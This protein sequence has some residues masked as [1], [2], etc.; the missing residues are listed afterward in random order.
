M[1]QETYRPED[2][3]PEKFRAETAPSSDT[4]ET[5]EQR[6]S[7]PGD[8]SV[9]MMQFGRN[10]ASSAGKNVMN[11]GQ[12][13]TD[14]AGGF[15]QTVLGQPPEVLKHPYE[16]FIKPL[17]QHYK[18][19]YGSD[20]SFRP[21]LGKIGH[22]LYEDPV[23]V[24]LDV[25]GV[26]QP[27]SSAL[28]TGARLASASRLANA[29]KT[30]DAA[31]TPFS[32]RTVGTV[33]AP[34]REKVATSLYK[35][36]LG[37]LPENMERKRGAIAKQGLENDI[38]LGPT[39]S[40]ARKASSAVK[41][42][43]EKVNGII[44]EIEAKGGK[45]NP[46]NVAKSIERVRQEFNTVAPQTYRN[47][48][49]KVLEEF[50]TIN[51]P[52]MAGRPSKA[53]DVKQ[54][55]YRVIQKEYERPSSEIGPAGLE[56]RKALASG[57]RKEL[58]RLDVE[59]KSKPLDAGEPATVKLTQTPGQATPKMRGDTMPADI[60]PAGVYAEQQANPPRLSTGG[61]AKRG[62]SPMKSARQSARVFAKELPPV[63]NPANLSARVLDKAPEL[64]PVVEPPP[65]MLPTG[66]ENLASGY[67]PEFTAS[68]T[69]SPYGASPLERKTYEEIGPV[70]SSLLP[71]KTLGTQRVPKL[72][73]ETVTG[74]SGYP[75]GF[76]TGVMPEVAKPEISRADLARKLG[77]P[78]EPDIP[79]QTSAEF[80]PGRSPGTKLT[81]YPGENLAD[82][83]E[84]AGNFI[85]LENIIKNKGPVN[86]DYP[87]VQALRG[88][89]GPS[90]VHGAFRLA[91]T[92]GSRTALSMYPRQPSATVAG[93]VRELLG[94]LT[95][96][97]YPYLAQPQE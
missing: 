49:A 95:Q 54:R 74:P 72:S 77:S 88:H 20:N 52:E 18:D 24:G 4:V 17:G 57:L 21:D 73:T 56:A 11:F 58:E 14:M 71:S 41:P 85:E 40:G 90:A 15:A 76:F 67:G 65:E 51:A 80:N 89:V 1:P 63:E 32:P 87:T 46:T 81:N 82:L 60:D 78:Y 69:G 43:M 34:I 62:G 10:L 25:A 45:I 37:D 86:L 68:R 6:A 83:N 94:E 55:T 29:T 36:S 47:A 12:G 30:V 92:I 59:L 75:D 2:L 13:L 22:E 8:M 44:G 26:V 28:R 42:L 16:Q 96:L 97:G 93:R 66:L 50:E 64:P 70:Y 48:I 19:K 91:P 39:L 31:L 7:V 5:P 9:P 27:V 23:G 79:P 61:F 33:T 3:F 35:K 84:Q 53:Q 38:A